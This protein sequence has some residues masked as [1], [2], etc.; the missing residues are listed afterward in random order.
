[1]SNVTELI[2]KNKE[3][4]GAEYK[5][6]VALRKS[7]MNRKVGESHSKE[8]TVTTTG[9]GHSVMWSGVDLSTPYSKMRHIA[10]DTN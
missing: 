8:I 3:W 2:R 4:A 10:K 1:M 5:H 7:R 9:D 6:Y